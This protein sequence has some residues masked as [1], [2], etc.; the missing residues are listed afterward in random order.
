[1]LSQNMFCH[2]GVYRRSLIQ[3]IDGFR[4]GDEGSQDYDLVLRAQRLP[5]QNAFDNPRLGGASF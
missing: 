1:M 2:L 3:K 5:R 4:C